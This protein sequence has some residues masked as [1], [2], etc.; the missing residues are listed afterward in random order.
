[1][2]RVLRRGHACRAHHRRD[3]VRDRHGCSVRL[4]ACVLASAGGRSEVPAGHC[5]QQEHRAADDRGDA[6]VAGHVHGPGTEDPD[7]HTDLPAG[8]QGLRHRPDP[9]RSGDGA[10]RRH[11]LDHPADRLGVVYRHLDRPD[12]H[13]PEHAHHLAILV[14]GVMRAA[15]RG[16]FPRTVAVVAEG[17]ARVRAPLH[18]LGIRRQ[19][20][21]GANESAS[22]TCDSTAPATP[23]DSRL[24]TLHELCSAPLLAGV[25]AVIP[26]AD[27]LRRRPPHRPAGWGS[28][29]EH[30]CAYHFT[31]FALAAGR[32]IAAVCRA[33]RGSRLEARYR[34]AAHCRPGQRHLP[35]PGAGRRSP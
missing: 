25:S 19:G 1:M 3:P 18:P 35:Q 30:A 21:V 5:R 26:A 6:V 17:T 10:G 28:R 20:A 11:R 7:L 24:A 33:K 32:R 8:G 4:V 14:G 15:D 29:R 23:S 31:P 9:L 22:T 16:V 2:G 13:R 12:H 34:T 27:D